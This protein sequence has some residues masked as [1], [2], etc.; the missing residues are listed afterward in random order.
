MKVIYPMS[1]VDDLLFDSTDRTLDNALDKHIDD[2]LHFDMFGDIQDFLEI[3]I[4]ECVRG[5]NKWRWARE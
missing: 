3:E 2:C 4:I 5:V 1:T